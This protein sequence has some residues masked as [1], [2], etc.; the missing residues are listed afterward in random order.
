M[1]KKQHKTGNERAYPRE[2]FGITA[3][4]ARLF[5]KSAVCTAFAVL[6]VLLLAAG[7]LTAD[8]NSKAAVGISGGLTVRGLDDK[9]LEFELMGKDYRIDLRFFEEEYERLEK[10]SVLLPVESE[11][12]ALA[13]DR[14]FTWL[15]EIFGSGTAK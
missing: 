10:Y 12:Y 7:F 2:I 11:L 8:K 3:R 5:L 15:D 1:R 14:A 13:A 6:I 9:Q 4:S